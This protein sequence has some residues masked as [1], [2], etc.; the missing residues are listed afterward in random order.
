[1]VSFAAPTDFFLPQVRRLAE[2]AMRVPLR[3]LPGANHLADSVLF[4]LRDGR[5]SVADAR[6]ELLRRSPAWFAHRLP[7]TQAHHGT[8]DDKVPVAHSDRLAD[9]VARLGPRAPEW[10]Y[11][12][13]P[14][15][16][17]RERTLPGGREC[18]EAFL[19]RVEDPS[20][21]AERPSTCPAPAARPGALAA[22]S[23]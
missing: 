7:P 2:R 5:I 18:A 13:Y 4:G 20:A 14:A 1:V 6:R 11:H 10:E 15:G 8:D 16:R 9:A 22:A 21:P 3:R 12:R 17:H 19:R 23:P